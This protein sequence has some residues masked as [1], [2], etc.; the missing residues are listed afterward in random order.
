M[1]AASHGSGCSCAEVY[2]S[3][4]RGHEALAV[5]SKRESAAGSIKAPLQAH[6]QAALPGL[7]VP[8]LE[9]THVALLLA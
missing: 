2:I 8:E 9:H 3:C 6:V 4:P 1:P 5:A 7:I